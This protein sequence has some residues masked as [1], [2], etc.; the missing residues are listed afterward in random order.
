MRELR[1]KKG[2]TR[3]SLPTAR[4]WCHVCGKEGTRPLLCADILASACVWYICARYDIKLYDKDIL[5]MMP[6]HDTSGR[7]HFS[8]IQYM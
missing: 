6:A 3:Y 1:R 7:Y 8:F 5:K 4:T 2:Y